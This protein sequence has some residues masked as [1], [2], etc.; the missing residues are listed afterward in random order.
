MF[1]IEGKG[2]ATY[3]IHRYIGHIGVKKLKN[4][5]NLNSSGNEEYECNPD[6]QVKNL[7]NI[8]YLEMSKLL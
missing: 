2:L 3:A 4:T 1:H 8:W 7:Q 5:P 6:L